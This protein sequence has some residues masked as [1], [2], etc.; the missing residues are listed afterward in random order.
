MRLLQVAALA[1]AAHAFV[2][3]QR[4]A[5]PVQ[6]SKPWALWASDGDDD[7]PAVVAP[8][9]E[10]PGSET[11]TVTS[12]A[13]VTPGFLETG[14]ASAVGSIS[15]A[16]GSVASGDFDPPQPICDR[17]FGELSELRRA[18]LHQ[19]KAG[20]A[21]EGV[22]TCFDDELRREPSKRAAKRKIVCRGP[23]NFSRHAR[24]LFRSRHLRSLTRPQCPPATS[25]ARFRSASGP[26][27]RS[28]C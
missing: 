13:L 15:D 6:T 11:E 24:V 17:G 8:E 23:A 10:E 4:L 28:R 21:Q 16:D 5:R 12:E 3:L 19:S 26:A 18:R 7:E 2:P 20:A 25:A 1:A 9:A 27:W 14:G 22:L